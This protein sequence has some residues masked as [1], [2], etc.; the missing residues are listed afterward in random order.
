MFNE[1]AILSLFAGLLSLSVKF[2]YAFFETSILRCPFYQ[3]SVIFGCF[4]LLFFGG[5]RWLKICTEFANLPPIK[6]SFKFEVWVSRW[7]WKGLFDLVMV[8]CLFCFGETVDNNNCSP[9]IAENC[10]LNWTATSG[11]SGTWRACVSQCRG[12]LCCC[13]VCLILFESAFFIIQIMC[14]LVARLETQNIPM[15][16]R[17]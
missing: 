6:R 10:W 13:K 9:I 14:Y 16:A 1:E 2:I 3:L 15:P 4:D 12:L 8:S 5:Y 11:R 7:K 17:L